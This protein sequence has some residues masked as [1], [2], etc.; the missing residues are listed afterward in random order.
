M[1][2]FLDATPLAREAK[3]T[4]LQ[5]PTVRSGSSYYSEANV[6]DLVELDVVRSLQ[7]CSQGDPQ[8]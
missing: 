4:N 3:P 8:D 5:T 6:A 2:T 1:Q 7:H